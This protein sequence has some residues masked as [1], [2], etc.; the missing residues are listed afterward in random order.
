MRQTSQSLLGRAEAHTAG[1]KYTSQKK[2]MPIPVAA[3]SKVG[4]ACWD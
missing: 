2:D 4:R 1:T 3:E